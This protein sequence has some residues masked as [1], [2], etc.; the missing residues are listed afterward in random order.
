[1][2]SSTLFTDLEAVE[3]RR[4]VIEAAINF[5]NSFKVRMRQATFLDIANLTS[6]VPYQIYK[7]DVLGSPSCVACVIGSMIAGLLA[8]QD[9]DKC[10]YDLI[11]A[12]PSI[13]HRY[14]GRIIDMQDRNPRRRYY[15]ALS[16]F[17]LD[18]LA[19]LESVYIRHLI[20]GVDLDEIRWER[21][22]AQINPN[23]L[24]D[25]AENKKAATKLL[26]MMLDHS[27]YRFL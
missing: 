11:E 5:V 27:Q 14:P 26:S 9:D 23:H 4:L 15:T 24:D 8:C 10:I 22:I 25:P 17:E 19:M 2:S 3:Q 6:F 18:D 1:M 12:S 16:M 13:E 7:S 21:L 20:P